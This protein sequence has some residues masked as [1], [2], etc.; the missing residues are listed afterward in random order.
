MHGFINVCKFC[1]HLFSNDI[2]RD[3]VKVTIDRPLGSEHPTYSFIYPINYGYVDGI[4]AG[5]G[6][7][8]DAYILGVYEACDTFKGEIIAV[9]HRE[10]DNEDKWVVAPVGMEITQEEIERET[11]FQEQWFNSVI[12]MKN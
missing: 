2:M 10:D 12:I 5:D 9:I 6:E 4:L 7:Y 8:Q 3:I 11:W 1:K